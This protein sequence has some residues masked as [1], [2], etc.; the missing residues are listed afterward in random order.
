MRGHVRA[1]RL[2]HNVWSHERD[3]TPREGECGVQGLTAKP[4]GAGPNLP[5]LS[6]FWAPP[7]E[8]QPTVGAGK[9]GESPEGNP[10]SSAQTPGCSQ[11]SRSG[12]MELGKPG[13][14]LTSLHPPARLLAQ[15]KAPVPDFP[16]PCP[17]S[18]QVSL[19]ER[20]IL[21]CRDAPT[22]EG[23]QHLATGQATPCSHPQSAH[24]RVGPWQH[25]AWRG[26]GPQE[27]LGD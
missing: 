23:I 21:A 22:P 27:A 14:T 19:R 26:Q 12:G 16:T 6:S 2:G 25:R 9:Q 10:V 1:G 4:P 17:Q 15:E 8:L 7:L 20:T 5:A 13:S 11:D 18:K 24:S 3:P